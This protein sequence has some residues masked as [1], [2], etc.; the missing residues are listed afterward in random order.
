MPSQTLNLGLI[1]DIL[2][3]GAIQVNSTLIDGGATAYLRTIQLVSNSIILRLASSS[4][5][6]PTATGPMFTNEVELFNSALTFT[7]SDNSNVI[8][9][10]PGHLSN[11]FSD[12]TEPYFWTPDNGIA[13]NAFWVSAVNNNSTVTLVIND[14][15][16]LSESEGLQGSIWIDDDA[17][18]Y[19]DANRIERNFIGTSLGNISD[20]IVGSVWIEG[21][22][23]HYI[24]ENQVE[25]RF[26]G[27]LW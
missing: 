22:N 12:P 13:W 5:D 9:K 16:S 3:T 4:T 8:L 19:V 25:R 21:N 11:T 1:T 24:D 18:H 26:N 23:L 10:G 6:D 27:N 14:G 17:F 2:W 20:A 15:I 7:S